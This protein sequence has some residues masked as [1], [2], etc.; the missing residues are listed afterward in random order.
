MSKSHFSRV[1]CELIKK[2]MKIKSRRLEIIDESKNEI[3]EV[4][5]QE[6]GH[7]GQKNGQKHEI[8]QSGSSKNLL[9]LKDSLYSKE[10]MNFFSTSKKLRV[11]FY[12]NG[13]GVYFYSKVSIFENSFCLFL[14]DEFFNISEKLS[15]ENPKISVTLYYPLRSQR[16]FPAQNFLPI[17]CLVDEKIFEK[18]RLEIEN[19]ENPDEAEFDSSVKTWILNLLENDKENLENLDLGNGLFL[20]SVGKYI[21]KKSSQRIEPLQGRKKTL[22]VIFL[23]ETR[24][25][26]AS[27]KENMIL[28]LNEK[29]KIRLKF[30]LPS[31]LKSRDVNF[32]IEVFHFFENPETS[33]VCADCKITEIKEEDK[34]FL[35]EIEKN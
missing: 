3:F 32:S 24:I 16:K 31:P 21:L 4:Y 29:L 12:Y 10:F 33:R 35:S 27:E 15:A 17:K 6:N 13:L 18:P 34:R 28:A 30:P 5:S 11:D 25:V 23:D 9:K 2:F 1:E 8:E 14:P 20:V 22:E 7:G 26:F 19:S